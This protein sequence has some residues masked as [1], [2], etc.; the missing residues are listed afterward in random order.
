MG[1][2]QI[3]YILY[4]QYLKERDYMGKLVY[5]WKKFSNGT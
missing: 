3:M 2:I 5:N 1:E 4:S